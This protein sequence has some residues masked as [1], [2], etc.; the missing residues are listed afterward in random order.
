MIMKKIMMTDNV[1]VVMKSRLN[2][3]KEQR[4]NNMCSFNYD[5]K[6]AVTE[7]NMSN[8]MSFLDFRRVVHVD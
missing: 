8:L 7:N 3:C 4:H 1:R 5:L 2:G 6:I